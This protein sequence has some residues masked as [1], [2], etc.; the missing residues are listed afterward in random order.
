MLVGYFFTFFKDGLRP[1]LKNYK[2]EQLRF[3][4]IPPITNIILI[5]KIVVAREGGRKIEGGKREREREKERER[6]TG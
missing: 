4:F 5:L 1:R 3:S 2:H 6:E